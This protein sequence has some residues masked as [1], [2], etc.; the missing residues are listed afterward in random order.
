[1]AI[2]LLFAILFFSSSA[3]CNDMP[4]EFDPSSYFNQRCSVCHGE[5]AVNGPMPVLF[6]QEPGYLFKAMK[7]FKSGFRKD[8]IGGIMN[9]M[10]KELTEP[11]MKAIARYLAGQDP[12]LVKLKIDPRKEGFKEKFIAGRTLVGQKNCMHCHASFHHSAPRLIGQ[13]FDYLQMSLENLANQK[14]ATKFPMMARIAASLNAQ[15]IEQVSTYLNGMKLMRT[16][17]E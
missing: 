6:G 7:E 5:Q 1:M 17:S 2:R 15:E 16:C 13:K 4:L 9:V 3:L 8:I 14:R 10:V 12:C 11:Q